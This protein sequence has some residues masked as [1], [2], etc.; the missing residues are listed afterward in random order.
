MLILGDNSF[1][2]ENRKQG[3]GL[4]KLSSHAPALS[5]HGLFLTVVNMQSTA[6]EGS[7]VSFHH[8]HLSS[9][10]DLCLVSGNHPDLTVPVSFECFQGFYSMILMCPCYQ[11]HLFSSTDVEHIVLSQAGLKSSCQVRTGP[12]FL[13]CTQAPLRQGFSQH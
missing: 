9:A 12:L 10:Q 11:Y 7:P 6:P 5:L 13:F 2:S 4:P 8:C 3:T 1:P